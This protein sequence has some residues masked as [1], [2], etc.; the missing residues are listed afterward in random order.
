MIGRMTKKEFLD[1][2]TENVLLFDGAMG[3][4]IY[5][6]GVYI[7]RCY[8]ELNLSQPKIIQKI[9]QSYLDAGCDCLETNTYGANRIKLTGFGMEH[10]TE[11]INRR[12]AE[13]AREV[14]GK[15]ALVVGSIGPLGKRI[16]PFGPILPEEAKAS[17]QQQAKALLA[18]GID[19]FILE[20]F[21]DLKEMEIALQ[22]LQEISDYPIIASMTVT[23]NGNSFY[24]AS[25]K[26][27]AQNLDKFGADA[28]GLNCSVGPAI[29]IEAIDKII[30]NTAKPVFCMPN[31]GFPQQVEG[32]NIY[33]VSDEYMAEYTRR[34]IQIGVSIIGGCCGTTPSHIK[35]MHDAIRSIVPRHKIN[36]TIKKECEN[37]PIP[38]IPLAE[39]SNLGKMLALG[40]FVTSIE[41]VP[42]R[43]VD[44]DKLLNSVKLIKE[45]GVSVINIPDGPRALS[46]MSAQH[47]SFLIKAETGMESVLHYA[48]RDRN[49]LG[50]MSDML[51]LDA[52]GQKNL[53][54]ITGDPPKM[55]DYPHATPVFDVDSIGLTALVNQL[56]HGLDM[57]GNSIGKPAG[58]VIGVGVNPG[59]LDMAKEL[60]RF[61]QKIA[62]GAEFA[63][64]Q[65]VFDTE[66]LF[67]F[68]GKIKDLNIPI[69][70]GVWPLVSIRNAEFMTNEVPGAQVPAAI[71]N[72]IK[73]AG[74]KDD[75]LAIGIE[76][77]KETIL[78]IKD[79]VQGV[80]VSAPFG[81]VKIA[82]EILSVLK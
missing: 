53:L 29:L 51:G 12:G 20:T 55:G 28:V 26:I 77:A 4:M 32:R 72:R 81:K 16:H 23:E 37:Q 34:F 79:H 57:A 44:P 43:G 62:A 15:N 69:I 17:F 66:R 9:H 60:E 11:E 58:Y 19:L 18:G 74:S 48:C 40:K 1:R 36:C 76:I 73:A 41:I 21:S 14:A 64:T 50:M 68:I 6:H 70:A 82:L 78:K 5:A 65:P 24:G 46:R 56:N 38:A 47:V 22:A 80:Q 54:I 71:M 8:D 27:I 67:D 39:K 31:A 30:K 25:P 35:A 63:M 13:I 33:M 42:P 3:T 59:A 75:A 61:R 7:N 10:L 45:Q 49:L 2:V 52:M